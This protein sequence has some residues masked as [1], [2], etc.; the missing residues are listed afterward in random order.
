MDL[1]SYSGRMNRAKYISYALIAS[2]V[3][4]VLTYVLRSFVVVSGL[5]SLA[6]LV[7]GSMLVVKRLHDI[8]RPGW[9][10]WLFLVPF[11]DI[12]LGIL[13]LFKKGTA[14]VNGYGPDP[15]AGV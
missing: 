6:F 4:W 7:I 12:Y 9:H 10:F 3:A 1:F 15:L 11:Y 2:I 13:L 14:G 5:I 8:E